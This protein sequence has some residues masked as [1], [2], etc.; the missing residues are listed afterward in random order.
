[1]LW[2]ERHLLPRCGAVLTVELRVRVKPPSP[3]H[4]EPRV[5]AS[6]ANLCPHRSSAALPRDRQR[7]FCFSLHMQRPGVVG[8][9]RQVFRA[10]FIRPVVP[11]CRL[12]FFPRR[13]KPLKRLMAK[14]DGVS[15]AVCE[16]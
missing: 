7:Q 9:W 5:E 12:C 16:I 2:A 15:V 11:W 13:F 10:A 14:G 3:S 8:G 6:E 4:K 1:M